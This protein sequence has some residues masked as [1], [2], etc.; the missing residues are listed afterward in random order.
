MKP[1]NENELREFHPLPAIDETLAQLSGVRL[2][3]KLNAN[4]GFWQMPLAKVSHPLTTFIISV[5]YKQ[6]VYVM[7]LHKQC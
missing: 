1:L 5:C 6:S 2:F 4:A 7:H 3:T